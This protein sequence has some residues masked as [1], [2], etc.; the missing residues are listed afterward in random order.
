MCIRDR[1]EDEAFQRLLGTPENLEAMGAFAEKR[2][3]DFTNLG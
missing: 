1:R 2:E 3:P